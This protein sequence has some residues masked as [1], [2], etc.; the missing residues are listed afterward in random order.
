[1]IFPLT[2]ELLQ[3]L[4]GQ[5]KIEDIIELTYEVIINRWQTN[6]QV[7]DHSYQN[8]VSN[9]VIWH[10]IFP[11]RKIFLISQFVYEYDMSF[12]SCDRFCR[13]TEIL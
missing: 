7:R 3:I 10:Y 2:L 12:F 4:E 1:M 5:D 6:I 9:H 11:F 8:Y 13:K